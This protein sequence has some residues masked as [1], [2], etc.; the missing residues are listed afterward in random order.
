M[1][2][3]LKQYFSEAV[4][5]SV[6]RREAPNLLDSFDHAIV[7]CW[8]TKQLG[9]KSLTGYVLIAWRR[10]QSGLPKRTVLVFIFLLHDGKMSKRRRLYLYRCADKSFARPTSRCILFDGENISFD[11]GLVIYEYIYSIYTVYSRI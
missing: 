5:V 1:N 9:L 4:C 11:D 6:I 8:V 7:S 10:K 2:V 3:K